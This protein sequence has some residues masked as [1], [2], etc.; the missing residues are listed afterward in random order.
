MEF[1]NSIETGSTNHLSSTLIE[2]VTCPTIP[3]VF[4]LSDFSSDANL[5]PLNVASVEAT[6]NLFEQTFSYNPPPSNIET[7][8]STDL[9]FSPPRIKTPPPPPPKKQ[10]TL[11]RPIISEAANNSF[12]D[13]LDSTNLPASDLSLVELTRTQKGGLGAI[14]K[15]NNE[16][17]RFVLASQGVSKAGIVTFNCCKRQCNTKIKTRIPINFVE[18]KTVNG[19]NRFHINDSQSLTKSSFCILQQINNDHQCEAL[20]EKEIRQI[21]ISN[22]AREI[23]EKMI[24]DQPE[25]KLLR[26]EILDLATDQV[27]EELGEPKSPLKIKK[28]N[29]ARRVSRILKKSGDTIDDICVDNKKDY[30]FSDSFDNG[31]MKLDREFA[32]LT[33]NSFLLFYS[34]MVLQKLANEEFSIVMDGTFP[35]SRGGL[36]EQVAICLI[37][38]GKLT[39]IAF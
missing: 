39:Q 8:R 18:K 26:S 3:P 30:E 4:S 25:R 2:G 38:N 19:K 21:K 36:Y 16:Q 6:N 11:S 27:H 17:R 10:K 33:G 32:K 12:Q 23:T 14:F 15:Q 13:D 20:T 7:E 28:L 37:A 29:L 35:L 1:E 5:T 31:G 24:Q 22:R 9:S 34:I